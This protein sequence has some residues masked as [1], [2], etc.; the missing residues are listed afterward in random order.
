VTHHFREGDR[1]RFTGPTWEDSGEPQLGIPD[2]ARGE[3]G[4]VIDVSEEA[5]VLVVAWD[6]CSTF[7]MAG[8]EDLEYLDYNEPDPMKRVP[9]PWA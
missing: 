9:T 5:G 8:P 1:V 6:R 7:D 3:E 2:L 4:W